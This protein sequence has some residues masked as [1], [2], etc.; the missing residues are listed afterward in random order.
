MQGKLMEK[1]AVRSAERPVEPAKTKKKA[2][3]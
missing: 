1:A 3:K 2:G